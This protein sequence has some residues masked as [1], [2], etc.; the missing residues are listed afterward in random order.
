MM[1]VSR[2]GVTT[3]VTGLTAT[4]IGWMMDHEAE[5]LARSAGTVTINYQADKGLVE[6][7]ALGRDNLK[8]PP[9]EVGHA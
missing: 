9:R 8:F 7:A 5:L 2:A 4:V 6:F 1:R 3:E